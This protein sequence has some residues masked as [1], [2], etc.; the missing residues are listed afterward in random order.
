[1]YFMDPPIF[2]G[3]EAVVHQIVAGG[4]ENRQLVQFFLVQLPKPLLQ[5]STLWL[6]L[7]QR[8]RLLIGGPSLGRPAEPAAQIGT[9]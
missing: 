6:L 2:G 3:S 5:E 9:R 4:S 8:Q 1:M 7:G